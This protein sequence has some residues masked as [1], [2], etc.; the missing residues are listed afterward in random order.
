MPVSG[1]SWLKP[2]TR[3]PIE[4]EFFKFLNR[5]SQS[6]ICHNVHLAKFVSGERGVTGRAYTA[7]GRE[8]DHG[9]K[10]PG[11]VWPDRGCADPSPGHDWFVLRYCR[12]DCFRD[13]W[14]VLGFGRSGRK[15]KYTA[16]G[17]GAA[18]EDRE[19][20]A[21]GPRGSQSGQREASKRQGCKRQ[22]RKRQGRKR[23]GRK[24]QACNRDAPDAEFVSVLG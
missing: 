5:S 2:P 22:G 8:R 14:R 24:R 12:R 7:H 16:A 1:K 11:N 9:A 23:Q 19:R 13:A 17:S 4:G 3:M 10:A 15:R 21:A 18:A 6:R 20:G